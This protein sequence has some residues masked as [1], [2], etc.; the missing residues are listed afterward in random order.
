MSTHMAA[1][2]SLLVSTHVPARIST[3]TSTHMSAHMSAHMSISRYNFVALESE[4]DWLA[5]FDIDAANRNLAGIGP[6]A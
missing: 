3:H 2:I 4:N 6:R 1:H 5:S